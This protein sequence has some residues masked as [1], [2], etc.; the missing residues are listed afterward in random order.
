MRLARACCRREVVWCL[1]GLVLIQAALAAVLEWPRPDLRD[2]EYGHKLSELRQRQAETPGRPLVLVAG[3]SRVLNGLRAGDL[4][5]GPPL[6][7]NFGLTRHGPVHQLLC[8]RRL[9]ADGV[10]PRAV[11]VEVVPPLLAQEC[12]GAEAVPV[13]RLKWT[14]LRGLRDYDPEPNTVYARWLEARAVPCYTNRYVLLSRLAPAFVPW[15]HRAD[16][17]WTHTDRWG[18]LE[19]PA[20]RTAEEARSETEK[21]MQGDGATMRTR[22]TVTPVADR[23]TRAALKLLR[24]RGVPAAVVLMPE[25]NE[26]R[27]WYR[28]GAEERLQDYLTRLRA[29]CDVPVID[30]R[31]WVGD[32]RLFRD[33]HH[34]LPAG[35]AQFTERFGREVLPLLLSAGTPGPRSVP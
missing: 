25:S 22:F 34:L 26:F 1:A 17:F 9:F 18:W 13:E 12:A 21:V 10:C 15:T 32:D 5:N 20:P 28:P 16:H 8:L 33:G 24:G 11:V 23:A 6:V 29:G 35:A 30:A 31:A 27:G 19:I 14:D 7:F 4:N 3:S 2:P